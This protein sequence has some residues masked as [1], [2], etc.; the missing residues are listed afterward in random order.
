ME[1]CAWAEVPEKSRVPRRVRTP[2][3][4][5]REGR[6]GSGGAAVA[7]EELEIFPG[8]AEDRVES[9]PESS[10]IPASTGGSEVMEEE[11]RESSSG[12]NVL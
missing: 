12:P 3:G 1:P 10:S 9:G 7:G 11:C 6:G 4:G 8:R 5:Q 2:E